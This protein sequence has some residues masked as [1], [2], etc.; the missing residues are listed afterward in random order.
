MANGDTSHLLRAVVVGL[1]AI[2]LVREASARPR[3]HWQGRAVLEDHDAP[4]PDELPVSI[5]PGEYPSSA[6]PGEPLDYGDTSPPTSDRSVAGSCSD[7]ALLHKTHVVTEGL[8]ERLRLAKQQ[9]EACGG[10]HRVLYVRQDDPAN[11]TAAAA[12]IKALRGAVGHAAVLPMGPPDFSLVFGMEWEQLR[13]HDWLANATAANAT[14]GS[15]AWHHC[16]AP[17]LVWYTFFA[18]GLPPGVKHVW[19]S[20]WDVGWLGSLPGILA[21][22]PREADFVCYTGS[23]PQGLNAS[24]H[25]AWLGARTWLSDSEV[26]QCYV[27]LTRY[28]FRLLSVF[29]VETKMRHFSFC[30]STVA[31]MCARHSLWCS[32]HTFDSHSGVVGKNRFGEPMFAFYLPMK[33][34]RYETMLEGVPPWE[35]PG[36]LFHAL[37]F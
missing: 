31:T 34:K 26:K 27:M 17:E 8:L 13:K 5:P 4:P 37:K 3:L 10:Y 28:S 21:T 20:E 29:Q 24:E 15:F 18:R 23:K 22:F 7:T 16:D 35:G 9:I 19:V 2:Q 6:P 32:I 1:L 36:L 25:W 33:R 12:D 14:T 11:L 30:E